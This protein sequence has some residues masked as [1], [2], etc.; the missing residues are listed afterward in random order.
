MR[1][2]GRVWKDGE[3]WLIEVPAL[4]AMTQGYTREEAHG[5]IKDLIETIHD[6]DEITQQ[7]ALPKVFVILPG[8]VRFAWIIMP[9]MGRTP[10][11]RLR[12]ASSRRSGLPRSRSMTDAK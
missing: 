7:G 9:A 3:H 2:E 4:H 10:A 1:F 5:M 8:I 6:R 11:A 12:S